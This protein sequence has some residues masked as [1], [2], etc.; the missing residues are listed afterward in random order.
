M[1]TLGMCTRSFNCYIRNHVD[2]VARQHSAFG[3]F[4]AGDTRPGDARLDDVVDTLTATVPVISLSLDT[5]KYAA[6]EKDMARPVSAD[7]V[8]SNPPNAAQPEH[9]RAV[10]L[11]GCRMDRES[12]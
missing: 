7:V 3:C 11:C 4:R 12:A 10:R 2:A 1:V 9:N 8:G 6:P 5:E